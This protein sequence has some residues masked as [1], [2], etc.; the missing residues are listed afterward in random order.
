MVR[1][2]PNSEE[3]SSIWLRPGLD[4]IA[5][6]MRLSPR[7]IGFWQAVHSAQCTTVLQPHRRVS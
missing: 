5:G 6:R 2:I 4:E 7:A 1:G 3:M